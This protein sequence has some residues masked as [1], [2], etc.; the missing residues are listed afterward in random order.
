VINIHTPFGI[1]PEKIVKRNKLVW[2][3]TTTLGM[4]I[5]MDF[6]LLRS[7]PN[8]AC[9]IRGKV[10]NFFPTMK[11]AVGCSHCVQ[12]KHD[13]DKAITRNWSVNK[14]RY[15]NHDQANVISTTPS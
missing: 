15:V 11:D 10:M 3:T 6:R 12:D 2:K 13:I 9:P 1:H 14:D 7:A 5:I 8:S 4:M